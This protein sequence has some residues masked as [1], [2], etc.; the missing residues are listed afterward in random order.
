ML[1][2]YFGGRCA[3]ASWVVNETGYSESYG[4]PPND[5]F[6]PNWTDAT[7]LHEEVS[8]FL[9]WLHTTAPGWDSNLETYP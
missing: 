9:V 5:S 6:D 1:N 2:T 7:P 8:E 4:A 3:A